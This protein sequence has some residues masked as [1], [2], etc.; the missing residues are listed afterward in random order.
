[1]VTQGQVKSEGGKL[2][3]G[4]RMVFCETIPDTKCVL[5]L[6][7]PTISIYGTNWVPKSSI[8]L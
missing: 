5:F 8:Q 6:N 1:M 7:T 3:Q 2:R 4:P